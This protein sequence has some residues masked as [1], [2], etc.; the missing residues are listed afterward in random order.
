MKQDLR[1]LHHMVWQLFQNQKEFLLDLVCVFVVSPYQNKK[2]ENSTMKKDFIKNYQKVH[3]IKALSSVILYYRISFCRIVKW[4]DS[5]CYN[6]NMVM[7]SVVYSC[8]KGNDTQ[9]DKYG[10]CHSIQENSR[11]Q[12]SNL[13]N[14][15]HSTE[16]GMSL[17]T[18]FLKN[19]DDD[20]SCVV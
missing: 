9:C 20:D 7:S 11:F 13:L 5:I 15:D 3:L 4:A 17:Q 19:E 2:E 1:K 18:Y 14:S 6:S 8:R 10:K 16:K 12:L